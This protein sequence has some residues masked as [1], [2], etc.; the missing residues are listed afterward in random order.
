MSDNSEPESIKEGNDA[1]LSNQRILITMGF[2]VL[3][4][5]VVSSITVSARFG[6]GFFVG[7]IFSF[8]NYYWL[9]ASLKRIFEA[10]A[11]GSQVSAGPGSYI[12]RYMMLGAVL[13][14]VFYSNIFPIV[15]FLLGLVSF[16]FAVMI[17]AFIRIFSNIFNQKDIS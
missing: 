15:A 13:L 1:P 16:V 8:I 4:G 7:G 2:V 17:E 6:L 14:I 5:T 12:W 11:E 10:A 3:I 9:K